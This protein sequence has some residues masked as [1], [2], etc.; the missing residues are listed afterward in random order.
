MLNLSYKK[1]NEDDETKQSLVKKDSNK[2]IHQ[3][4]AKYKNKYYLCKIL[5]KNKETSKVL[6]LASKYITNVKNT[7]IIYQY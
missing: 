3:I 7:D 5:Q 1:L 4:K 2:L 6:F